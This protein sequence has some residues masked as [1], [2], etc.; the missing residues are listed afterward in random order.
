MAT[1]TPDLQKVL[2]AA[3]QLD[4]IVSVDVLDPPQYLLDQ[5]QTKDCVYLDYVVKGNRGKNGETVGM[6]FLVPTEIIDENSYK[7]LPFEHL[8]DCLCPDM[9]G[10]QSL[11]AGHSPF[12]NRGKTIYYVRPPQMD[13]VLLA[14]D[15]PTIVGIG[16]HD[17]MLA[18]LVSKLQA[19]DKVNAI[20]IEEI[21]DENLKQSLNSVR[22]LMVVANIQVNS[23]IAPNVKNYNVSFA[24][25][26]T[27]YNIESEHQWAVNQ[28]QETIAASNE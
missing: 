4:Y 7:Q 23:K 14:H 3:K 22:P 13:L 17:E 20:Q 10:S 15:Q 1:I 21:L 16:P 5:V 8:F 9:A 12:Y 25:T 26:E 18:L 27:I 6:A 2:D 11:I 24:I 28:L 19:L